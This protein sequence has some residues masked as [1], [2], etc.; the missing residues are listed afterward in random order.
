[1]LRQSMR[2]SL[3]SLRTPAKR[4]T[5]P[6]Q[7]WVWCPAH[8]PNNCIT[9]PVP[10][11]TPVIPTVMICFLFFM[12]CAV[13]AR[14]H[15][16]VSMSNIRSEKLGPEAVKLCMNEIAKVKQPVISSSHSHRAFALGARTEEPRAQGGGEA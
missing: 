12:A 5:R 2:L 13:H 1:M 16:T 7:T 6:R 11:L 4:L 14:N 3:G 9:N 8:L 15:R 10:P